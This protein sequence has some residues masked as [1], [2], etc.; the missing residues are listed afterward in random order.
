MCRS[1]NAMVTTENG[2][3]GFGRCGASSQTASKSCPVAGLTV[4]VTVLAAPSK[5]MTR[6]GALGAETTCPPVTLTW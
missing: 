5:A 6:L 2:H 1:Q 3:H 4:T